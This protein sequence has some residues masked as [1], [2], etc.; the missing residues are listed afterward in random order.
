M[1]QSNPNSE[2]TSGDDGWWGEIQS[3]GEG[4]V[5]EP[6]FRAPSPPTGPD[7]VA[8]PPEPPVIFSPVDPS[9]VDG[10]VPLGV[11]DG[12]SPPTEATPGPHPY[13]TLGP[14]TPGQAPTVATDTVQPS[15]GPPTETR[16]SPGPLAEA[17]PTLGPPSDPPT[18]LPAAAAGV[19]EPQ[20]PPL[21][22]RM[23][24]VARF[25]ASLLFLVGTAT[26]L[27][28]SIKHSLTADPTAVRL[29]QEVAES[30]GPA[31]VAPRTSLPPQDN[32][33]DLPD[34]RGSDRDEA[35]AIL[36]EAGLSGDAVKVKEVAWVPPAG[37][38]V[39][40]SP[41]PGTDNPESVELSI[42]KRQLPP[43]WSGPRRTPPSRPLRR[44]APR[45]RSAAST[46]PAPNPGSSSPRNPPRGPSSP[47]ASRSRSPR[48]GYPSRWTNW[49]RPGRVTAAGRARSR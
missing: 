3:D 18:G 23:A 10:A 27:G 11:D 14:S 25:A 33:V 43:S 17:L 22:R 20:R 47:R 36:T 24:V 13:P 31:A 29:A 46:G 21:G 6:T 2:S 32:V 37:Q 26:L 44:W 40:Q 49:K 34:V 12:G 35:L 4:A 30:A 5:P 7:G 45:R 28:W 41:A 48:L 9:D 38:V 15:L 39:E 19:E 1:P 8:P 42:S 16:P